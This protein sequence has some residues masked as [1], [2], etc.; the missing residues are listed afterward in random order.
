MRASNLRV[1]PAC[2]ASRVLFRP[3]EDESTHGDR[4]HR[5]PVSGF[6]ARILNRGRYRLDLRE[7][8]SRIVQLEHLRAYLRAKAAP[9]TRLL[10]HCRLHLL[11]L[12]SK[13]WNRSPFTLRG[14]T[15]PPCTNRTWRHGKHQRQQLPPMQPL[16]Q[17]RFMI[18]Y[19]S[20]RTAP[21]HR[22]TATVHE[23][24]GNV[25]R[26]GNPALQKRNTYRNLRL[27]LNVAKAGV[28][29]GN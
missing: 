3:P 12:G 26:S 24:A 11:P 2:S 25:C 8:L 10:I 5:T 27:P 16:C 1:R 20:Y 19:A 4:I 17:L 28:W 18:R 22:A 7:C 13:V 29:V 14:R 21:L 15:S 23:P 9:R 6:L